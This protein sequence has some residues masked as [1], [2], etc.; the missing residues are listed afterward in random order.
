MISARFQYR[1][2]LGGGH[3]SWSLMNNRALHQHFVL[4]F[5]GRQQVT[6]LGFLNRSGLRLDFGVWD[7]IMRRSRSFLVWRQ[8]LKS[9]C[10]H[11]NNSRCT[12]HRVV[13]LSSSSS[14]LILRSLSLYLFSIVLEFTNRSHRFCP[15]LLINL[16]INN[17]QTFLLLRFL[18]WLFT[19]QTADIFRLNIND[20]RW[21]RGLSEP[22]GYFLGDSLKESFLIST[23]RRALF[24]HL[25]IKHRYLV[26]R[27]SLRVSYVYMLIV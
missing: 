19:R 10:N 12:F 8:V 7:N 18:F 3:C 5:S 26:N 1:P 22:C 9:K 14:W 21:I 17:I 13:I 16:I 15:W 25:L 4:R 27:R 2:S 11:I 20:Y 6:C 24:A 23:W